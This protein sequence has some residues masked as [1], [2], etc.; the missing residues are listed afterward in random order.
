MQLHTPT[1]KED[2]PRLAPTLTATR[3][4]HRRDRH[5]RLALRPMAPRR[6]KPQTLMQ[7][8]DGRRPI[9]GDR[10]PARSPITTGHRL[11]RVQR[12]MEM[13]PATTTRGLPGLKNRLLL[14]RASGS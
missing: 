2:G 4:R 14:V 7:M 5:V 9:T 6:H 10:H 8:Q 13:R 3:H 12:P 1:L 11:H